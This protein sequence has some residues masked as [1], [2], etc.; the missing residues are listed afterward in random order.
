[1]KPIRHSILTLLLTFFTLNATA[2]PD[3]VKRAAN[4]I[5]TLT[6]FRPD[7]SI[8]ASSHGVFVGKNGEAVSTWNPFV[9]ASRAVI[10]DING[11]QHEVDAIYGANELYD[12]CKFRVD[13]TSQPVAIAKK[14][15][16]GGDKVW[17]AEYATKKGRF[18]QYAIKNVENFMEE[19]YAYY[20]FDDKAPEN[21]TSSAFINQNGELIG[22]LQ[23]AKNGTEIYATDAR[24]IN[25]FEPR[26]LTFNDGA[27][28]QS[29]IPVA[30]P[31]ELNN[32]RLTLMMSADKHESEDSMIYQK[33][34]KD[35]IRQF[36]AEVD[37]YTAK[38][39]LLVDKNE[40]EQADEE[41]QKAIQN[42]TNKDEAHS[43]YATLIQQKLLIKPDTP[44]EPWTFEKARE[45][46]QQAYNINP[47]A[48]YKHQVAQVDYSLGNY[49]EACNTFMELAGSEVRNGEFFFEAAQCQSKLNAPRETI[50]ALL[51]SAVNVNPESSIS[52]PYYLA[53]GRMYDQGQEYRKAIADYNKYDTLTLGRATHDFYYLRFKCESKVRFYQQAL[54]DIA[55]AI[56]LNRREPLYYAEMASLQLRINEPEDAIR[57]CDICLQLEPEYPDPYIV[58]GV[59]LN[60]LNR[61]EEAKAAF[62][63]AKELGDERGE[64][65]LK[66]YKL[67]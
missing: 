42:A 27:L 35:F 23:H 1:M 34:I 60:N 41:M 18:K 12:V 16:K 59:A 2:Q 17:L 36:P 25:T 52:A 62:I 22:I 58:K 28:K 66:K 26:G 49:Q 4:S 30:L 63:K 67:E 37:G 47:T 64:E 39:R 45:E 15:M 65:M 24:F 8:L 5:F 3:A 21:A 50:M 43:A 32:A 46:A 53:R 57:S 29:R 40:F 9:G 51:D 19:Q 56:I 33:Y 20:I 13:C 55:H 54:N 31:T 38:A 10:V 7:G 61:K 44:Y 6:T 14:A 11:Q 48:T